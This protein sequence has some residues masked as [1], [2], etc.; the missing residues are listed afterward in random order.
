MS[1]IVYHCFTSFS[2][3]ALF[4]VEP[5]FLYLQLLE[6]YTSHRQSS[7]SFC[8][9]KVQCLLGYNYICIRIFGARNRYDLLL[10]FPPVRWKKAVLLSSSHHGIF[11]NL[12]SY[13]RELRDILLFFVFFPVLVAFPR[14]SFRA[15]ANFYSFPH[16]LTIHL[17]L[18]VPS[19]FQ[20]NISIFLNFL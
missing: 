2:L 20:R 1:S 15:S 7:N 17:T 11:C 6:R 12:R 16:L 19:C 18:S 4:F 5:T 3:Q 9:L 14:D 8:L 13:C 10:R